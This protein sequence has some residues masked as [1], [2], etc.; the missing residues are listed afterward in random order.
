MIENILREKQ[1]NF[2]N[3]LPFDFQKISYLNLNLS[4]ENQELNEF[5]ISDNTLFEKYI[6]KKL[7]LSN[8]VIAIGGYVENRAI[9]RKSPIFGNDDNAR[10]FHLGVDIWCAANTPV[11]AFMDS[12]IHS[13]R[14]NNNFG[15]YGGTIILE[16][17]LDNVTFYTLYGHLSL[18]SLEKKDIGQTINKAEKFAEIGET[19]ENGN[20]VPHLHFQIITDMLGKKGDFFGVASKN[21]LDK[22]LKICPDPNLI[23]NYK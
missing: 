17:N 6:S 22:Y 1:Q 19:H 5:D 9:Y 13:F 12:K 10:T 3:I 20:W 15:D 2:A 16:H 8:S 21:E 23:L 11:F 14:N 7:S 18:K 4:T